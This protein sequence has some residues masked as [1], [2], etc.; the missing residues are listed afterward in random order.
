MASRG[1]VRARD[2]CHL[3]E[4]DD[5]MAVG[6]KAAQEAVED[7]EF[8]GG[9]HEGIMNGYLLGGRR[10][11]GLGSHRL[12][13]CAAPTDRQTDRRELVHDARLGVGVP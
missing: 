3:R 7:G 1:A 8:A 4:E 5:A 6:L 9:G 12:R 13:P 11:A 2:A 10:S